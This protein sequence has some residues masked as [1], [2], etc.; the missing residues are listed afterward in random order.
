MVLAVVG[1]IVLG[2]DRLPGLAPD[3]ARLLRNLRE[4]ATGARA[5]LRDELGPEF[6]DL[7]LQELR[8][9]NPKTAIGR[10]LLGDDVDLKSM[11]PRAIQ[12]A[13]MDDDAPNGTSA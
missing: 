9:L 11:N 2:P 6:A 7:N 1:L 4:M 12:R 3:A 10:A 8:N 13:I 5:Q